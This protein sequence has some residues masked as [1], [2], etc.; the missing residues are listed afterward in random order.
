MYRKLALSNI[1]APEKLGNF[2]Q[3]GQPLKMTNDLLKEKMLADNVRLQSVLNMKMPAE[4]KVVTPG[5]Y[6]D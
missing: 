6:S 2:R 3:I 1:H 4:N 5:A